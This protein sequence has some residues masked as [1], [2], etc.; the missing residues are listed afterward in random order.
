MNIPKKY[1]ALVGKKLILCGGIFSRKKSIQPQEFDIMDIRPSHSTIMDL[2]TKNRYPA[3]EL[4]VKNNQLP[5][6]RW[7]NPFPIRKK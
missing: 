1:V 6:A 4:L 3:F 7:T 2:E 5:R